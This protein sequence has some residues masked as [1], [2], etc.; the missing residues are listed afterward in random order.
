MLK[1]GFQKSDMQILRVDIK[2]IL[3]SS[4]SIEPCSG[5]LANFQAVYEDE[6]GTYVQMIFTHVQNDL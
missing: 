1:T 4:K 5:N 6:A 2:L 3:V